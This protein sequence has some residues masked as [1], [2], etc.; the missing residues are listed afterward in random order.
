M[1]GATEMNKLLS[2]YTKGIV[3]FKVLWKFLLVVVM[4]IV[5]WLG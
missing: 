5:L 1:K 4:L 2:L 3:L